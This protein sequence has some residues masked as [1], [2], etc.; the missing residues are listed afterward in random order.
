MALSN[1]E[2]EK[3]CR[4][5]DHD[6]QAQLIN[7]MGFCGEIERSANELELLG[8]GEISNLDSEV[9][10]KL[11]ELINEDLLPCVRFLTL[12]T[13]KLDEV[14]TN[15]RASTSDNGEKTL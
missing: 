15:L 1:Q 10:K 14:F 4:K 8:S 11:Q 6:I 12:S 5:L 7:V 2:H 9:G 3:A 13:V